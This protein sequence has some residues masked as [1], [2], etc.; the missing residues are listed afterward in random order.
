MESSHKIK[1][2]VQSTYRKCSNKMKSF[3]RR[4]R[5]SQMGSIGSIGNTTIP[6]ESAEV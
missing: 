5:S 3:E 2:E 1:S 4:V 6:M